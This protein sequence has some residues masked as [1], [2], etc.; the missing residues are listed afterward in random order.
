MNERRCPITYEILTSEAEYSH[1]GLHLLSR[2]LKSL[3]N[4]PFNTEELYQEALSRY[5][6]MSIQGV[7]PKLSALLNIKKN[8]FQI[9]DTGG[10]FILKPP[11]NYYPEVPA[12]EDLTM[13]L[14]TLLGIEVPIHGLICN[15]DH[16]FTYFI[17]RFDRLTGGQKLPTEDFAQLTKNNR[18]AKYDFSME[19]II[20]VLDQY[21]TFPLI[22]KR[23]LL[24]RTLF[25]YLTGNEDMHLKNFSLITRNNKT[26]LAPAYDFLNTTILLPRAKEE[27]AL[28]L[29]GKKNNLTRK[30]FIDYFAYER[31]LLNKKTVE[32]ILTLIQQKLPQFFDWIAISFLSEK[33]KEAYTTLLTTRAEELFSD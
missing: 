8:G 33:M 7:Q 4:L 3:S 24:I 17:K 28:P 10:K 2:N 11:S 16:S 6:K 27:I 26:E 15:R 29:K 18:E 21:C 5:D 31:L 22:E 1:A 13:K 20:A 32:E 9:V 23:K 14:A 19:K 25:N 30:D 12:N